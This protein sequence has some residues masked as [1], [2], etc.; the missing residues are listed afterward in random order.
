MLSDFEQN[1]KVSINFC[2]T[3]KIIAEFH[4][5]VSGVSYVFYLLTDGR[6]RVAKLIV[7]FLQFVVANSTNRKY[8]MR[9]Q[10]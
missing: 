5:N 7:A 9:K 1:R 4:G 6:K 10:K 8:H 3:L 2:N